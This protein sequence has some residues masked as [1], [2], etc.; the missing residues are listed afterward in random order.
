VLELGGGGAGVRQW[1]PTINLSFWV[2]WFYDNMINLFCSV[3]HGKDSFEFVWM[4][5]CLVF[6]SE[7]VL[8][9]VTFVERCIRYIIYFIQ[10][11]SLY[12]NT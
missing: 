10:D 6:I 11:L 9:S 2:K 5:N 1:W 3:N 8:F 12:T 7:L 4:H